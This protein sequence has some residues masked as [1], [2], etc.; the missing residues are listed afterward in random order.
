MA[1]LT[2]PFATSSAPVG[3]SKASRICHG[4]GGSLRVRHSSSQPV[5]KKT[6]LRCS[7]FGVLPGQVSRAAAR[8]ALPA[9][10]AVPS[11]LALSYSTFQDRSI[12][13]PV[14][15]NTVSLSDT[16]DQDSRL[17]YDRNDFIYNLHENLSK[18][19]RKEILQIDNKPL[20]YSPL[21]SLCL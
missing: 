11:L 7:E 10:Y 3:Q 21:I 8:K 15:P 13:R 4:A 20:N 18:A 1:F 12:T 17:Q 9:A 14:G 16:T 2:T 5:L 6:V 19:L